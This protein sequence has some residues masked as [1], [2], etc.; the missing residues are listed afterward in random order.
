MAGRGDGWTLGGFQFHSAIRR[1]LEGGILDVAHTA[2][3]VALGQSPLDGSDL[4]I[5]QAQESASTA[6]RQFDNGV[7]PL[8]LVGVVA[9]DV[10]GHTDLGKAFLIGRYTLVDDG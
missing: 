9:T 4:G 6:D 3:L 2:G 8:D 7:A 10:E 5:A 1:K